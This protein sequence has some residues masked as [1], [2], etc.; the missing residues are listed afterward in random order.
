[1][2]VFTNGVRKGWNYDAHIYKFAHS[3][4]VIG[5]WNY[6]LAMIVPTKILRTLH[7][8]PQN[9]PLVHVQITNTLGILYFFIFITN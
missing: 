9:M 4:N 2:N 1:V 5:C 8:T 7:F 3:G 6:P